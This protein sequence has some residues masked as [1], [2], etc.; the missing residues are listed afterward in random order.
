MVL[1]SFSSPITKRV[2]NM[3]LSEFMT[4]FPA[5]ATAR[6]TKASV[7]AWRV[8]LEERGLGRRPSL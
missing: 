7:S 1:D 3:T 2:Y 6:F 8:S 4:L 5:G